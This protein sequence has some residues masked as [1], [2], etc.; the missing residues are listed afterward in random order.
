M[1][2][3]AMPGGNWPLFSSLPT[4]IRTCIV[5]VMASVSANRRREGNVLSI[6][7]VVLPKRLSL[8]VFLFPEFRPTIFHS[9]LLLLLLFSC[10]F[11]TVDVRE[12]ASSA[13]LR[14]CHDLVNDD[15]VE[16]NIRRE[17]VYL[18]GA[19]RLNIIVGHSNCRAAS[20]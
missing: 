6:L 17:A 13:F 4:A 20:V 10:P 9:S 16:S 14:V 19:F 5:L 12:M 7:I 8:S 15:Q 11:L 18:P 3:V 2:C 1:R